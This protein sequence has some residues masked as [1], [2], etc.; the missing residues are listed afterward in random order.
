MNKIFIELCPF[1]NS[2][3]AANVCINQASFSQLIHVR[4]K[5]M[6]DFKH[7]IRIRLYD[8]HII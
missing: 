2:A 7:M 8:I 1:K 6:Q 4:C 3:F 5:C